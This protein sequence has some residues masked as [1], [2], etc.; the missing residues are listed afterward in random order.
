VAGMIET[1]NR[2][3]FGDVF[4]TFNFNLNAIEP[5]DRSRPSSNHKCE[6]LLVASQEESPYYAN[7]T[8]EKGGNIRKKGGYDASWVADNSITYGGFI[9]V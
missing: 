7:T 2:S 8:I 9:H 3:T 1:I 4:E 5:A 6:K